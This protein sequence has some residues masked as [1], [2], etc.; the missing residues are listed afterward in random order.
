MQI[1]IS[2][3]LLASYSYPLEGE[4]LPALTLP[5]LLRCA[6]YVWL[7]FL[8]HLGCIYCKGLVQDLRAFIEQWNE[9]I[10]PRLIFVHPNTLEEGR[11]FFAVFYSGA[12]FI[13]DPNL[14]L[15]RLFGVRRASLLA[16]VR[17]SNLLRFWNLLRRGLSNQQS[18][19]DP[20]LLHAAFLFQNGT[21]VWSYHAK[22]L[23]DVPDWKRLL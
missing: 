22:Y 16:Q 3:R 21:L 2:E 5:D 11:K 23:S 13:A 6:P 15:Y 8:R 12:A 19:A 4:N 17:P 18:T 7:Q 14:R 20:T 1:P 9:R 10:R